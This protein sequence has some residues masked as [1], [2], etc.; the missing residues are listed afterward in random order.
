MR[1]LL[2]LRHAKSSWRNAGQADHER[3]LNGRG[4][5]AADRMADWLRQEGLL[6]DLA[7]VST[8][9][10]TRETW[11]RLCAAWDRE[12]EVR[13]LRSLYLAPPSRLLAALCRAPEAARRLLLL[14]HNPGIEHLAAQLA[15]P[16]SDPRASARLLE[17][18][19]TAGLALFRCDIDDW[20]DLSPASC[21]LVGFETPRALA[22]ED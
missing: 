8:A 22:A 17:K 18:Y 5:E 7:L 2:L 3:P 16:G 20:A 1:T 4:R 13:F 6:P 19:P 21:R 15:G 10:R 14:G 11:Q 9:A 12:P